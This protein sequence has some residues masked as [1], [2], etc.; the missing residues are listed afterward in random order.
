MCILIITFCSS[1]DQLDYQFPIQ[2]MSLLTTMLLLVLLKD[3]PLNQIYIQSTK[4]EDS[5]FV[6][7]M[8]EKYV[9]E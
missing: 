5:L 1:S 6:H 7:T 8:E 4:E 9:M 3:Q 2:T